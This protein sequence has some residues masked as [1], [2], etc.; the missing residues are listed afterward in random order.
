MNDVKMMLGKRVAEYYLFLTWCI[1]APIIMLVI[2]LSNLLSAKRMSNSGG[3]G[4]ESYVYPYWSAIVY[5]SKNPI[6]I[7]DKFAAY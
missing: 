1:I 4:Y 7:I 6:T 5:T 3:G 2:I